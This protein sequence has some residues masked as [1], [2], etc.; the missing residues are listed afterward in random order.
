MNNNIYKRTKFYSEVVNTIRELSNVET[1]KVG[2]LITN[3]EGEIVSMGYN[4]SPVF[5]NN[6]EDLYEITL[7]AEELALLKCKKDR[8]LLVCSH[9]PC[10]S[11]ASKIFVS[12]VKE[13]WFLYDYKNTKGI[14]FLKSVGINVLQIS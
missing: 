13:V 2:A 14:E 5:T 6:P 12:G 8:Y 4:T 7:H 3:S 1:L 9:A 10:L 11:C